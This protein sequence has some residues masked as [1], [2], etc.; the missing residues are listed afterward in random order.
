MHSGLEPECYLLTA[1]HILGESKTTFAAARFNVAVFLELGALPIG[2]IVWSSPPDQFDVT[3]ARILGPF[4]APALPVAR[5]LPRSERK[6]R[7]YV[8]GHAGGSEPPFS[9]HESS[10]LAHDALR[11]LYRATTGPA[12]FGPIFNEQWSVIGVHRV[13]GN[14]PHLAGKPGRYAANEGIWIGAIIEALANSL[15]IPE[16]ETPSQPNAHG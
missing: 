15:T 16:A 12:T 2:E 4:P 6:P 9:I 10:L 1:T 5:N 13:R 7:V 14:L 3:L 11:L 8:I